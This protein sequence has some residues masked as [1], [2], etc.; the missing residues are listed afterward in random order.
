[1]GAVSLLFVNIFTTQQLS[2]KK[3]FGGKEIIFAVDVK[4]SKRTKKYAPNMMQQWK[5]LARI[6]NIVQ[7]GLQY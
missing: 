4:I 3:L 1:M 5:V 7:D 2:F 6:L